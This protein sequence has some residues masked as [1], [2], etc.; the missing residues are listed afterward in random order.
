MERTPALGIAVAAFTEALRAPGSARLA[1][2][3]APGCPRRAR[4]LHEAGAAGPRSRR[5]GTSTESRAGPHP[6]GRLAD[7][8]RTQQPRRSRDL[9]RRVGAARG[10]RRAGRCSGNNR[11]GS[12]VA[13][14]QRSARG[15]SSGWRRPQPP[16]RDAGAQPFDFV[17]AGGPSH[18]LLRERSGCRARHVT[19][20]RPRLRQRSVATSA[21]S[22]RLRLVGSMVSRRGPRRPPTIARPRYHQ[23]SGPARGRGGRRVTPLDDAAC[24]ASCP[25]CRR[26]ARSRS[27][28]SGS[29]V[30]APTTAVQRLVAGRRQ[31]RWNSELREVDRDRQRWPLASRSALPAWVTV[32]LRMKTRRMGR[33]AIDLL[34][35]ASQH[36]RLQGR[37]V[38]EVSE[39]LLTAK[40]KDLT[41][42]PSRRSP[43]SSSG[44]PCPY[45]APQMRN[46]PG[47]LS[48]ALFCRSIACTVS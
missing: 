17:R 19:G 5:W 48:L 44:G 30:S 13:D 46:V 28:R 2:G 42:R 27:S 20:G 32:P 8:A 31:H 33:D 12:G 23:R 14:P 6:R 18:C 16:Q 47:T 39:K 36:A 38:G 10:R 24:A 15:R 9:G 37:Q 26:T 25:S 45:S 40:A 29:S 4:G 35:S 22:G 7:G 11:S 41:W 43:P 34:P 21:S 3:T 1:P